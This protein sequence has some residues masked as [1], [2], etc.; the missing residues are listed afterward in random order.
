[1]LTRLSGFGDVQFAY[2]VTPSFKLDEQG[3][4][5]TIETLALIYSNRKQALP[6]NSITA[7]GTYAEVKDINPTVMVCPLS[8]FPK[9]PEEALRCFRADSSTPTSSVV[10]VYY[11]EA[12]GLEMINDEF[13]IGCSGSRM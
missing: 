13:D 2:L 6:G 10:E 4:D 8:V 11:G 5:K 3:L 7:L 1:M 9:W 12:L